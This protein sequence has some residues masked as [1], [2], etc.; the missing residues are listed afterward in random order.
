MNTLRE[1]EKV[2]MSAL[3]WMPK[4]LTEKECVSDAK[5]QDIGW[6]YYYDAHTAV[7]ILF[8]KLI[9]SRNSARISM[10]IKQNV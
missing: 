3:D 5:K 1:R 9:H 8:Q 2:G 7:M 10:K 4:R 6:L